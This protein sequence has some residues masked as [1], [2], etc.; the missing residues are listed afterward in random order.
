MAVLDIK[1][2]QALTIK[3]DRN[4]NFSVTISGI[5]NLDSDYSLVLEAQNSTVTKSVGNG[6]T[7]GADYMTIAFDGDE[8]TKTKYTGKLES[9]DKDA[10]VFLRIDITLEIS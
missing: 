4:K 9:E 10:L 3:V 5:D 7:L 1:T 6:I 2:A 8:F